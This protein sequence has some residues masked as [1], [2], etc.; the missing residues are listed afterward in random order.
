MFTLK[1]LAFVSQLK[2]PA[3]RLVSVY[4]DFL[5]RYRM[6]PT[7][8]ITQ[9]MASTFSGDFAKL[10]PRNRVAQRLFSTTWLFVDKNNTFHLRF[11]D[12]TG[13]NRLVA[14]DEPV[15]SSTEYETNADTDDEDSQLNFGHFVL[16]FAERR[17]PEMPHVGWRVGRGAGKLPNRNVDLLLTKPRDILGKS[18]ASVHMLF[19]FNSRS[20]FLM[21]KAGSPK[22]PVGFRIGTTWTVLKDGEELLLHQ[23][24]TVLRVG[25]C[26]YE[27]E[28]T[29]EEMHREDYFRQRDHFLDP[30]TSIKGRLQPFFQKMPGDRFV[31]RGS[32]LEFGTRDSGTFG[33]ITQGV[34]TRTGDPVAIKEL[35]INSRKSHVEAMDEANMGRRFIVSQFRVRCNRYLIDRRINEVSFLFWTCGASMVIRTAAVIWK[36]FTLLCLTHYQIF[37]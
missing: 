8:P 32:F 22:A 12:R 33:W 26:E 13:S 1:T 20:G 11:M 7:D 30:I 15:E 18:L 35:R 34:D 36:S 19:H 24:S 6:D 37:P 25:E 28:Y 3:K 4:L 29:V 23:P 17:A 10:V 27:L 9:E 14:P 2:T 21:L 31:Q 5:I 16:S